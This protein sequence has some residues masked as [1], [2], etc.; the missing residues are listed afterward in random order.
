MDWGLFW[1]AFGA[2][3]GTIGA[4][5]TAGAVIVA[6]WQTK[7]AYK[8]KLKVKFDDVGSA[9]SNSGNTM[10]EF[11]S[12]TVTNI[13]N[14]DVVIERWGFD[15]KNKRTVLIFSEMPIRGLPQAMQDT[16]RSKFPYTL[17]IEQRTSFYYEKDLF[18]KMIP[19]CCQSGEL[20]P[21]KPIR[22]F[23]KDS[24]GRKY[25]CKSTKK[26]GEYIVAKENGV[27]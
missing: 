14:R 21:K 11:V 25:Y 7:Y 3:G 2:I 6:L 18:M 20:D 12:L 4:L 13:G 8:K 9:I 19:E 15:V 23:V 26:A 16:F 10:F 24:T 22:F 27:K 5:A 17:Q 1:A